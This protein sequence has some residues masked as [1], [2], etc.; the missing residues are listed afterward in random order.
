MIVSTALDRRIGAVA[1][2]SSGFRRLAAALA[3]VL[4]LALVMVVAAANPG[5]AQSVRPPAG[6]VE[7][8]APPSDPANSP[9][10]GRPGAVAP[11]VVNPTAGKGAIFDTEM[12]QRV[13]KG[14]AGKVTIPD[15][16]AGQLVQ[17]E[18]EAWRNLRNGKVSTWGAWVLLGVAGAIALYYLVRGRMPISGGRTGRVIPRFSLTE[19]IVHWFAAGLWLIL[20]FTGLVI[21]FGRYVLL[22][23][24]GPTVFS[25]IASASLQAHNLMGPIFVVSILLLFVTFIRGNFF[26]VADFW[27]LLKGGGFFGGH[28]SSHRYN[29]G[30][31]TWY[32]WSVVLGLVLSAS[33]F[34]MLFPEFLG[35]RN[36]LQLANLA[37]AIA[38]LG[39]IA[40]GLGHI[41][42]ATIGMDG[43]LEGMTRGTVDENWAKEHHDLWYEAHKREATTNRSVAEAKAALGQV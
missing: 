4:L 21:L 18:G 39:F 19:R 42:L 37:H 27:W 25:M 34:A 1:R 24:V 2:R 35:S 29:F 17:S 26:Q 33:G 7:N 16:M 20:A 28:A 41:Y 30:E 6:A 38:A 22:P 8:V 12:W 10:G 9:V 40:F 32:W 31:K 23:V 11:E 14:E 36:Y 3:G 13:R 5:M 15:P 43:A